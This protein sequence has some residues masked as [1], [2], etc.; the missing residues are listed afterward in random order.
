MVINIICIIY[1]K[2]QI[3]TY[4]LYLII[5][6][7]SCF[8]IGIVLILY[9]YMILSLPKIIS[10]DYRLA[11]NI[12]ITY[13]LEDSN[14]Y[15]LIR[16]MQI[17]NCNSIFIKSFLS[18][19]K[20]LFNIDFVDN[21][22]MKNKIERLKNYGFL[23]RVKLSSITSNNIKYITLDCTLNSILKRV[24]I[25]KK[26]RLLIPNHILI[27]TFHKQLGLPKNYI[28]INQSIQDIYWWYQ[29]RGFNWID[30][31]LIETHKS[32]EISLQICE[33]KIATS[34]IVCTQSSMFSDTIIL[35][36]ENEI[37]KKLG[38]TKGKILNIEKIELGI[39]QLKNNKIFNDCTYII[40]KNASGL[41]IFF[42]YNLLRSNS[43][44]FFQE[45]ITVN[46]YNQMARVYNYCFH[47]NKLC[48]LRIQ[49]QICSN[50]YKNIISSHDLF[51]PLIL[52]IKETMKYRIRPFLQ[53]LVLKYHL[54][55]TYYYK[56][57]CTIDVYIIGHSTYIKTL[58]FFPNI[59]VTNYSLGYTILN[60]YY[61]Y[62]KYNILND[63]QK[64][65]LLEIYPFKK[66]LVYN[67]ILYLGFNISLKKSV[68]EYIYTKMKLITQFHK[69]NQ[70]F[71]NINRY[72][73]SN[74]Y[75]SNKI[76]KKLVNIFS[77]NINKNVKQNLII[78]KMVIKYNTL[79]LT[80]QLK[81]G[82]LCI[83]ESICLIPLFTDISFNICKIQSSNHSLHFKYNQVYVLPK[84]LKSIYTHIIFLMIK[85][86]WI[87]NNTTYRSIFYRNHDNVFIKNN[88][89]NKNLDQPLF[90][91]HAEYSI[92]LFHHLSL[93][94][95]CNFTQ[96][97]P[98]YNK[99]KLSFI[100]QYSTFNNSLIY[101]IGSG[102]QFNVP[103]YKMPTFRIE[104][105]INNKSNYFLQIRLYSKY[106]N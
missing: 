40:K 93:Y 89:I 55:K 18:K 70:R 34:C 58:L 95:F 7:Y 37:I 91:Y 36:K 44:F 79:Y 98:L 49:K 96:N 87:V 22:Y 61:Q 38:F 63:I 67:N 32:E 85:I 65:Q 94:I 39:K 2:F 41:D 81:S 10:Y 77:Q 75:I 88:G 46:Y 99:F 45:A 100:H 90:I 23:K 47:K 9:I 8:S 4:K 29:S 78:F 35:N 13:L 103:I 69:S 16:K 6:Q 60:F 33:G 92:Y 52:Q 54:Y 12:N 25:I 24:K 73:W 31:Q 11:F 86:D 14:T 17:K 64:S 56:Q 104:Y 72:N 27:N 59:K 71:I 30:I 15:R 20:R 66:N 3:I 48:L 42:E 80:E 102:I 76:N 50:Y 74:A 68:N 5:T 21:L 57:N 53:N 82:K 1:N 51:K 19:N 84:I 62:Y 106:N 28:D 83:I 101:E 43:G 105:K 97:L 26:K